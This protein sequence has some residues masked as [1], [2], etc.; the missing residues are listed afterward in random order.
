MQI[1]KKMSAFEIILS[2]LLK[3]SVSTVVA[4]FTIVNTD[5]FFK[6]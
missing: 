4:N 1:L 6:Y 5:L 2:L 3:L